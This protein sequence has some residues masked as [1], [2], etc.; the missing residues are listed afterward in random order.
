MTDAEFIGRD[1][2]FLGAG[3]LDRDYDGSLGFAAYFS[4]IVLILGTGWM[5][6]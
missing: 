1:K 6:C 2:K 5:L 3:L 4:I